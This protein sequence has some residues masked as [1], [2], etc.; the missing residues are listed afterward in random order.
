MN[1]LDKQ[2]QQ[3]LQDILDYGVEKKDRTGT[4]TKSIFGYTIRHK[5][6]D[7][8]IEKWKKS[9]G[10]KSK[11]VN[12]PNYGKHHSEETKSKMREKALGR[13]VSEETKQKISR[14]NTGKEGY[15]K[16]KENIQHSEWMKE[17]NPFRG[18]THSEE[19]KLLLSE[20]NSKPKSDEHKNN[21]SKNSPNNKQCII[22][23]VVYR[24]VAEAARQL[25]LSENTVRGRVK[26]K[27]FKNWNYENV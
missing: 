24:S 16:D 25:N 1:K 12:N 27:N 5:M 7:D 14:A 8:E 9:F 21:I 19:V 17:N 10:D 3:L 22:E 11:G 2:Y 18:K 20:I 6:S 26:N 13:T 15:W 4:G 23:G